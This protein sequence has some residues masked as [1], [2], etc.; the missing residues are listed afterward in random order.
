MPKSS[1]DS[2]LKAL[3]EQ[4]T[5]NSHFKDVKDSLF[6]ESEFFDP[7]DLVQVKYEMLRRYQT[8]GTAATSAAED[9]GFSRVTFYQVLRRFE[10]EGMGGLLPK[11]RGPK[12]AHKLSEEV[13]ALV[14]TAAAEKPAL[15]PADL[16]RLVKARFAVSVHPRSIER[17]LVRRKKKRHQ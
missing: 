2:K 12:G 6:Q 13:M 11:S 17:A 5:L 9:Y 7:R 15:R 16:S 1:S 14:E 8:E 4:G 10:E 3:Q